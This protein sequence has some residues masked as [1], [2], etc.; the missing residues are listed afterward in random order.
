TMAEKMFA[1]D[2][3][4]LLGQWFR[5][6]GNR[7][8]KTGG[9]IDKFIGDAVLAYWRCGGKETDVQRAFKT[10]QELLA[11]AA[12][13]QWPGAPLK[14]AV[15]LHY[16]KV[17]CSNIGTDAQRDATIIG[18]TVNTVF[19][20]ESLMKELNQQ[21]VLSEEFLDGLEDREGFVDL[22]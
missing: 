18:D 16:G 17:T 1:D 21:L 5:E 9:T 12:A 14:I 19:R 15:A 6:V 22:G 20:L 8:N 4:Q 7:I 3:A 11:L 2:L 10:A 13:Q